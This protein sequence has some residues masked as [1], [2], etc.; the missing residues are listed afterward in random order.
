VNAA[1]DFSQPRST[2]RDAKVQ[3]ASWI[4]KGIGQTLLRHE[5]QP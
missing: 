1:S 2:R 4:M 5:R 3:I